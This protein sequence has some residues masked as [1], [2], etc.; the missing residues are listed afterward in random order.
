MECDLVPDGIR[1]SA[2]RLRSLGR[3]RARVRPNTRD[4][5]TPKRRLNGL[6][7]RQPVPAAVDAA[8]GH[9]DV[10]LGGPP[11]TAFGFTLNG[12]R[13]PRRSYCGP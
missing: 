4:V 10:G 6:E 5:M 12:P 7:V 2:E 3:V 13:K 11:L 9:A 1:L 8:T